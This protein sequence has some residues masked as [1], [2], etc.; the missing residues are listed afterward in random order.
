MARTEGGKAKMMIRD[1]NHLFLFDSAYA[2][3]AE[4]AS[5]ELSQQYH[6]TDF[7]PTAD[8]SG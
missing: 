1:A 6:E 3:R 4:K 5:K 7:T 2:R 8:C